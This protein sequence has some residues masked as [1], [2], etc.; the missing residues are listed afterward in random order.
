MSRR[1]TFTQA[2][3]NAVAL[4]AKAGVRLA[5]IAR[6]DGTKVIVPAIDADLPIGSNDLDSRLDAYGA[7]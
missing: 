6:P 7:A 1:V 4:A 2:E 3:I 5:M